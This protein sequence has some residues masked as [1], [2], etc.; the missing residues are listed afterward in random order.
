MP[1][2]IKIVLK[3]I[4]VLVI[5]AAGAVFVFVPILHDKPAQYPIANLLDAK[6]YLDT[7]P[8]NALIELTPN[9]QPVSRVVT[10][11]KFGE[12]VLNELRRERQVQYR[13]AW[14][15]ADIEIVAVS[16]F[17]Q[18]TPP[19]R[20]ALLE[21]FS[22]RK[23]TIASLLAVKSSGN[24]CLAYRY[25]NNGW[26]SGGFVLIDPSVHSMT[27]NDASR[28]AVAGFDYLLGVPTSGEFFAFGSFPSPE[29]SM[30]VLDYVKLCAYNGET[31]VSPKIRSRY[32][33]TNFPA[34]AC[35]RR[36]IADAIQHITVSRK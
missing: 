20:S 30:V 32:G 19:N 21:N 26:S 1:D 4:V 25:Q 12:E 34:V 23:E 5:I 6:G 3:T 10:T 11:D 8:D 22:L 15:L 27:V 28:C 35:I 18:M 13:P 36:N 17:L 31:N 24:G 16:N 14:G 7:I 9:N 33:V 2:S 29:T